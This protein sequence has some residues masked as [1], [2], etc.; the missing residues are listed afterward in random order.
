MFDLEEPSSTEQGDSSSVLGVEA[1]QRQAHRDHPRDGAASPL[2]RLLEGR[3]G[4][5]PTYLEGRCTEEPL[6][7]QHGGQGE[8]T[9]VAESLGGKWPLT[10]KLWTLFYAKL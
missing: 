9:K 10:R 7:Y 4:Q 2:C 5:D 1:D 6:N 3:P 8:Q